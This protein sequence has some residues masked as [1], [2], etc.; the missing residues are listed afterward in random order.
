[1]LVEPLTSRR[2]GH[3]LD[4]VKLTGNER[5]LFA[6]KKGLTHSDCR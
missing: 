2:A 6:K 1:L 4:V 5:R 3:A